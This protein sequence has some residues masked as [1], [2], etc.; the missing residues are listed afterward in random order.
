[1]QCY[2]SVMDIKKF[3]KQRYKGEGR[4]RV[5]DKDG[6][7][8]VEQYDDYGGLSIDWVSAEW[9]KKKGQEIT[10]TVKYDPDTYRFFYKV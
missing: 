7:V 9:K 4:T 10:A 1:M 6:K 5:I 3:V 8:I 2:Q